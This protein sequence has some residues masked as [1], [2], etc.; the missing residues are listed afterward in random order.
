MM[1]LICK[2]NGNINDYLTKYEGLNFNKVQALFRKKDIRVNNIKVDKNCE[3]KIGD[4]IRIFAKND[5]FYSIKTI[6]EDENIIIVDKPKKLEVISEN[7]DITLINI[8]NKNYFCVHRIDF[9]TEGLVI[10]AKNLDAKNELD[11]GFKNNLFT[12]KYITIC[13]NIPPKNEME[14]T[15]YLIK[16]DNYVKITN[17]KQNDAKTVITQINLINKNKNYS[18]LDV[19]LK[20]GRTHQIRAHLAYHNLFVLGDDKYGDFKTNKTLN[21]KSQ[22][23]KCYYLKL[24]FPQ[25]SKLSYL[26][27]KE[28]F[29]DIKSILDYFNNL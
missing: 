14:F 15:D 16:L 6:Y 7:R 12:K 26:T 11:H 29:A 18:L 19:L 20:T 13:K 9:N 4:E 25:N 23:L 3:L 10:F 8:I 27:N 22:I 21:L 17:K 5:Y 2:R 24:N 1:N 28:F